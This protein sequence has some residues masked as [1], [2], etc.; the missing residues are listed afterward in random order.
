M[1]ANQPQ[2]NISKNWQLRKLDSMFTVRRGGSPRPIESY[3]TNREDGLNWLKIGD[4]DVGAKYITST[5][6]KILKEGLSRT[7]LVKK[8][9]FILSNS[10]SFG[11]PYIMNIDA[12]IHDGWLTFQDIK[13]D[14][15]DRD[16]LYYLLSQSKTQS[17]FSSISAGSGVQNLKK[18]TVSE[19]ELSIPPISE[20]YRIVSV[21]ETWDKSIEKLTQ[22]IEVKTKIK[23]SLMQDLLTGNKRL[24]GFSS[25]WE[26][27][28]LGKIAVFKKGKGLS[29]SDL[30]SNG[31]YEAIH[32]GELFTKYNEYIENVISRTNSNKN[33][34]L[35]KKNDILMP[36]SDVTPRGL[37]TA[38]YTDKDG[39]ILG[40]DI[41]V[42]RSSGSLN[43][44]FFCY[45]V[46]LN[47]KDV[48][49]L[50]SGSTVFHLYG[51][52]MAKFEL[53]LPPLKEQESI[54]K[55]L[56]TADKEITGLE[57]KLSIIK[58][59]KRY[60]LNNLITG[61]IRTPETLSTKITK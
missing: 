43:G 51:S 35:S 3:I 15:L 31:K 9:D 23:R 42:I 57:K 61:T 14:I 60:L 47:K 16:F 44:L 29:K 59:Q 13:T 54:V 58:E 18:E 34:F 5:S 6:S 27:T 48:I 41:L 24:A 28:N 30:D 20:Q 4:I 8:G 50:V 39:V 38:S 55:I 46:N 21:L 17:I 10:M 26:S 22:K 19:V 49:K 11:R 25:K 56:A 37:S 40:G 33:M 45:L 1:K 36:T 12:C 53:K 32:Y 52:D 7:T 2:K